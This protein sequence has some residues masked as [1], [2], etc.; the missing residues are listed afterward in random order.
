M[1]CLQTESS[2]AEIKDLLNW[3]RVTPSPNIDSL[4]LEPHPLDVAGIPTPALHFCRTLTPDV[5]L[6]ML[7]LDPSSFMATSSPL[8]KC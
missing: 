4:P 1:N 6:R 7:S 3:D 2:G 8:E 5:E